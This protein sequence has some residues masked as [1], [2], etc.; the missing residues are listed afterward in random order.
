MV[1]KNEPY[2][3]QE[4]K[5][6]ILYKQSNNENTTMFTFILFSTEVHYAQNLNAHSFWITNVYC[7]QANN[8]WCQHWYNYACQLINLKYEFQTDLSELLPYLH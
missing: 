7:L 1:N 2:Y 5:R 3:I 4:S 8:V 6:H